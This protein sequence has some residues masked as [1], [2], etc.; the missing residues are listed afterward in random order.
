MGAVLH[1]KRVCTRGLCYTVKG[2][3]HGG[4]VTLYEGLHKRA[5][6]HCKRVCTQGLCYTV[7]GSPQ[8]G[9]VTL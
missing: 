7:K 9:C 4:C 6:L 8:G 5:A 1:C 2:S 3:A